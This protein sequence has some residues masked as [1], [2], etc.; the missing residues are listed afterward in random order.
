MYK[1]GMRD[2]GGKT[3]RDIATDKGYTD[4]TQ[5]LKDRAEGRKLVSFISHT[6]INTVS[7][8]GNGECLKRKMKAGVSAD[9]ATDINDS[10]TAIFKTTAEDTLQ[11]QSNPRS[12]LHTVAVNGNWK[13]CSDWWKLEYL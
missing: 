4:I 12:A 7:E 6:E 13:R 1:I 11:F 10:D 9:S 5:L 2:R 3:A 8:S